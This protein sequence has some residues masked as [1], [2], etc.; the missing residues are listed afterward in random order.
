MALAFKRVDIRG[1]SSKSATEKLVSSLNNRREDEPLWL[2]DDKEPIDCYAYL[3]QENY[4]F[5][6]FI[7]SSREY[8]VFVGWSYN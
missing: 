4:L 3:V 6:T 1:L 7:M 2:I 8:R 5:E